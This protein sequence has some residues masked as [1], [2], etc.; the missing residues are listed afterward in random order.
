ML[1]AASPTFAG[2]AVSGKTIVIDAGHGGRDP[3]AVANGYREKDVTLAVASDVKPLLQALGANVIMT[4]STDVSL[5]ATQ[6]D[7]L[8]ARVQV[9]QKAHANAFISIHENL[10]ADPS[11]AG[12]TDFYGPA[13]GFY[14]GLT[15]SPTDVGRSYAL[16]T[17]VRK[18]V[19]AQTGE[20]D[21]GSVDEA[22]WVLGNPGVPAILVETGFISNP[23]EAD[24][25]ASGPYQQQM[26]KAITQGI[27]DYFGS[28]DATGSPKAP[29]EAF[30]GCGSQ[31]AA[32]PPKPVETWVQT[33]LPAP[34]LSGADPHAQVFTTLP[35]FSYLKVTDH[36]GGYLLVLNPQTNGPGWVDASKVGPS[37]PPPAAP[38]FTPFWVQS[39][40]ATQAW[41]GAD[42]S[43]VAFGAQPLWSYFQ[44]LA[45]PS[46]PRFK[47]LVAST[48]GVAYVDQSAVGP[49]GPPPNGAPASAAA[50]AA[51][52][53]PAATTITVRQGDTLFSLAERYD[54]SQDDLIA[55]NKLPD[56]GKILIGQKLTVP[57][58]TGADASAPAASSPPAAPA[59]S[60]APAAPAKAAT[61]SI[62]IQVGDRL[63]KLAAKYGT[64]V[65]HLVS[66]NQLDDPDHIQI[67]Q[68][69]LVPA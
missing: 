50:P 29:A 66:L 52:P 49:S 17:A 58:P 64:T 45:P 25:L 65:A 27:V 3:G 32:A 26:A 44:V 35:P 1:L 6:D 24:K 37:G 9:A 48:G 38:A 19:V 18:A 4:R 23:A 10:D 33:F 53:T 51:A 21:R 39:F 56:D 31:P 36:K 41:S 20:T 63:T 8:Q 47:V 22:F 43:A 57:A 11:V 15:N 46:G 55:A 2:S 60:P 34:L 61:K 28:P 13:C 62:V 14:S 40:Q 68:T 16:A 42:A 59:P 67:G 69:L 12:L 30:A 5:G 7:D 54:V